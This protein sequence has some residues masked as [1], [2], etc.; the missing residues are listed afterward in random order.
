ME[1]MGQG[2]LEGLRDLQEV[3]TSKLNQMGKRMGSVVAL[4]VVLEE[5][6]A[7]ILVMIIIKGKKEG[8]KA[9]TLEVTQVGEEVDLEEEVMIEVVKEVGLEGLGVA[10]IEEAV[11]EEASVE[12]EEEVLEVMIEEEEGLEDKVDM[13]TEEAVVVEEVEAVEEVLEVAS[14]EEILEIK[15]A[16]A[17]SEEEVVFVGTLTQTKMVSKLHNQYWLKLSSQNKF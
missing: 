4:A 10:K 17:I 2:H 5:E 15:M 11:V 6:E 9:G 3:K 14:D 16:V 12:I 13:K 1:I 7:E 8:S